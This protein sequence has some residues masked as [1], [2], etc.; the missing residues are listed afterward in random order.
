MSSKQTNAHF[1][2]INRL[3]IDAFSLDF[4][5]RIFQDVLPMP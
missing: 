5:A 2:G 1:A 4:E 3:L